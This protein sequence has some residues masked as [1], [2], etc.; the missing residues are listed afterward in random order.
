MPTRLREI[1]KEALPLSL[2]KLTVRRD[3]GDGAHLNVSKKLWS[4]LFFLVQ[5]SW[6]DHLKC[7]HTKM[8]FKRI[9]FILSFSVC[10]G[11][12]LYARY[13]LLLI[14]N[15]FSTGG[16]EQCDNVTLP[17]WTGTGTGT[18]I[19]KNLTKISPKLWWLILEQCRLTLA[20]EGNAGAWEA[21]TGAV[22]ALLGAL[23][24]LTGAMEAH[25]G[26]WKALTVALEARSGALDALTGKWCEHTGWL[27]MTVGW[28]S[29]PP[30][31]HLR[32]LWALEAPVEALVQNSYLWTCDLY[33]SVC[34]AFDAGSIHWRGK[35]KGVGPWKS[36]LF[37]ALW[38]GIEPI[39]ECH[40]GPTSNF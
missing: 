15:K 7:Q 4:S 12:F 11:A 23:C 38:N 27:N 10:T 3:E 34:V 30:L 29:T 9:I 18:V 32:E 1:G 14:S 31:P 8:R 37:W 28:R 13:S 22:Q 39:G 24:S 19:T 5:A 26:A 16:G 36:R 6:A 20:M 25:P 2:W 17:H 40:L 33:G 21:L 35:W